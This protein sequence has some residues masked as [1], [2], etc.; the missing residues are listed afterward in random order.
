M[1]IN[2]RVIGGG[3]TP[4]VVA[5]MSANHNGDL[6]Q[7]LKVIHAA[8]EA[9]AHAI[10]FQRYE[11]WRLA[12]ARGGTMTK[13]TSG[14]WS[15]MTLGELYTEAETP[16]GWWPALT[17][18]CK[19]LDLT[20]FSSVFDPKDID[21]LEVFDCPAYKISSFD[22]TNRDL[23]QAAARTGKP[24]IMSTGMANDAE[25]G[26]A[27]NEALVST[28]DI[29]ILHCVSAYP[30]PIGKAN[31]TRIEDLRRRF[32]VPVGFSDH[33]QGYAAAVAAVAL[34]ADIIEKHL[35]LTPNIGV[36]G[37]FSADFGTFRYMVDGVEDA[38]FACQECA[39]DRTYAALRV[40]S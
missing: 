30:T 21:F 29:A 3:A 9:G 19:R 37:A 34:G 24:L 8:K 26:Q 14:P 17:E 36:D 23:I 2:D 40:V 4:Y 15:G 11:A 25:I 12:A 7:A 20:W 38:H 16:V 31:L 10:K 32:G 35:T 6:G 27:L 22:I 28:T 18:C 13:L 1:Q 33:T 5:E 39:P